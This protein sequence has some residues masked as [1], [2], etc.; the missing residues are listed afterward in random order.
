MAKKI[1][2]IVLNW[3]KDK[4]TVHFRGGNDYRISRRNNGGYKIRD[5]TG[6]TNI[7]IGEANTR[8]EAVEYLKTLNP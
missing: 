8:Y 6:N 4:T 5:I 7:V 2:K 3:E 1:R